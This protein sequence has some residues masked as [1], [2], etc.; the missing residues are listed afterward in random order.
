MLTVSVVQLQYVS[1]M[2]VNMILGGKML[3]NLFF[4]WSYIH[5]YNFIAKVALRRKP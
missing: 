2:C 1:N 4:V 3:T 5:F